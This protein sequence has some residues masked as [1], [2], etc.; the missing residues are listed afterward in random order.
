ML[1]FVCFFNRDVVC[2]VWCDLYIIW[3]WYFDYLY[4]VS[5]NIF[6]VV[7]NYIIVPRSSHLLCHFS[8]FDYDVNIGCDHLILCVHCLHVYHNIFCMFIVIWFADVFLMLL[9]QACIDRAY[10]VILLRCLLMVCCDNSIA[11]I[12][13]LYFLLHILSWC[14][15]MVCTYHSTCPLLLG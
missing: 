2:Y 10:L 11:L 8:M 5:S 4:S 12:Y 13:N 1:I 6:I 9:P 7:I 14:F 3:F 15:F